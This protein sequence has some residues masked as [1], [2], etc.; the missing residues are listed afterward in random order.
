MTIDY[1]DRSVLVTG[2]AGFIGSHLVEELVRRQ[3]QVTIVDNW[4]TGHLDNLAAVIDRVEI[5]Q[6]DLV[7]DDLRPLLTRRSFDMIFHVAANAYVPTSVANPRKDFEDNT[8]ATFNMLEAV[9]DV[10]PQTGIIHTSSAAV[11]GQGM[12]MP[13]KEDDPTLPVAPYG[14]SKLAAERYVAVYAHVYGLRTANVRLFPVYGP[15]LRKQVVYDL[16]R[17]IYDNPHELFIYGD[18]S[19]VRDF[20]HVSNVVE[21]L[22]L[23]AEQSELQGEVYNIAAE[24]SVPIQELAQ[25]LCGRMRVN[26]HFV[27]SGNVRPGDAQRWQADI[28]RLQRLGY[29]PRLRLAEGLTDTVSW[30][31][32]DMQVT[33]LK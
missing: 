13:L 33:T 19:Q 18:G 14:V 26:P 1:R 16:M 3:A 5:H 8:L 32:E 31:L 15:R 21:A 17:K 27:Y 23:V 25:M 6:L 20:N 30:F 10:A 7:R 9:R 28:S 24:E 29:Q 12:R 22:L 2:G 11:Y 4:S